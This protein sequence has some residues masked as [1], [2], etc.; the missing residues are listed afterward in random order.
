MDMP[1]SYDASC[2]MTFNEKM[3]TKGAGSA[4]VV[5]IRYATNPV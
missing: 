1:Y 5:M 2:N 4:D 3:G